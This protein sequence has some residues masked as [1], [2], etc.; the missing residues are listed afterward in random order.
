[1][2]RFWN[3]SFKERAFLGRKLNI[4]PKLDR[5]KSEEKRKKKR[6]MR[7]VEKGRGRRKFSELFSLSLTMC[8]F[9]ELKYTLTN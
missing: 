9:I 2:R 4:F 1:M 3:T 5:L 6:K 8:S 7:K